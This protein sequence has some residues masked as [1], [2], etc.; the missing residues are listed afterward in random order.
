MKV[1]FIV[2]A[3]GWLACS[4]LQALRVA[5]Y[6]VRNY[7]LCDRMADGVYRQDY[8]KPESEKEALWT[9]LREADADVVALQEMGPEPF[10]KELQADLKIYGMDYPHRAILAGPDNERHVAV[11]SR[12]PFKEVVP[13]A[14][15]AFNYKGEKQQVRRGMLQVTF[16]TA[17][18]EWHLFVVHLKSRWSDRDDDPKSSRFRLGEAEALRECLLKLYPLEEKPAYLLVGDFN[19]TRNYAPIRRFQSKGGV[20]LLSLVPALD[21]RGESWTYYYRKAD[22][23]ERVDYLFATQRLS[24]AISGSQGHIVDKQPEAAIASDHRLLYVD[25]FE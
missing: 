1:L 24:R 2:I 13:H 21:S 14:S 19:D 8:P 4:S 17:G 22:I 10:L 9:I 23:Y 12:V 11:L 6:N 20:P 25:L 18:Q 16:E 3:L 15:I 5:S 7:L